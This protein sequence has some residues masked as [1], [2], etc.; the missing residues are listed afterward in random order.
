MLRGFAA[1]LSVSEV[2]FALNIEAA[3]YSEV[4]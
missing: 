2:S 4:W 1:M 3:D